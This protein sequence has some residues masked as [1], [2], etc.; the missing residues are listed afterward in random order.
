[1][2][3]VHLLFLS[4]ALM[5]WMIT[6]LP[7]V[8]DKNTDGDKSE[9]SALDTL[10]DRLDLTP[11]HRDDF[12]RMPNFF[13]FQYK[14]EP[15]PGKR[16]WMRISD[17]MWLERYESGTESRYMILGRRKLMNMQGTIIIKVDGETSETLTFNDGSFLAFIPDKEN[18]LMNFFYL[19]L[20]NPDP[21]WRGLASMHKVE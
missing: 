6:G 15:D 9:K 7:V 17:S 5:S 14:G 10:R 13:Y 19:N 16:Y 18:R 4:A 12:K 8:T 3:K 1:M 21:S 2:K 11:V 20:R